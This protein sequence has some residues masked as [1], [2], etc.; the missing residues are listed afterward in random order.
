MTQRW[1]LRV[2][3]SKMTTHKENGKLP[4]PWPAHKLTKTHTQANFDL[5]RY[6]PVIKWTKYSCIYF[7]Q[8]PV[9]DLGWRYLLVEG[10]KWNFR[11]VRRFCPVIFKHSYL[12]ENE[13][14]IPHWSTSLKIMIGIFSRLCIFCNATLHSSHLLSH[15]INL[16]WNMWT[17]PS[18]CIKNQCQE[19][20]GVEREKG[21][22]ETTPSNIKVTC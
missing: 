7:F 11:L 8:D 16:G 14:I 20:Q 10:Q 15:P 19:T 17:N 12:Q 3:L 9:S 1:G 21:P 13:D 22:S 5:Y 6:G 18:F 4:R 2:I